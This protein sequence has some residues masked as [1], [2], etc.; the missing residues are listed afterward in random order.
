[1]QRVMFSDRVIQNENEGLRLT[2]DKFVKIAMWFPSIL[3]RART[4]QEINL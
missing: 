4:A 2:K 1:M 3:I